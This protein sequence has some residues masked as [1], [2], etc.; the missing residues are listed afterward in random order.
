MEND[1]TITV[2]INGS[3]VSRNYRI[4]DEDLEDTVDRGDYFGSEVMSMIQ[5]YEKV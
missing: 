3:E 4:S 5:S 2:S 1:I